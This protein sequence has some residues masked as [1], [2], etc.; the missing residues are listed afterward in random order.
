MEVKRGAAN[1]CNSCC[2]SVS[3]RAVRVGLE[4]LVLRCRARG[5][6]INRVGEILEQV[7][8]RLLCSPFSDRD[9]RSTPA[10]F[11]KRLCCGW[12]YFDGAEASTRQ[13]YLL[14]SS[15][16]GSRGLCRQGGLWQQAQ[17]NDRNG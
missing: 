10:R 4:S 17:L 8:H 13:A 6:H 12:T 2:V 3:Y 14:R 1:A 15:P 11:A 16:T 9:R 5:V 7:D